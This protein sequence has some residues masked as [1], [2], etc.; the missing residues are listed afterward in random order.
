VLFNPD[1]AVAGFQPESAS[2]LF[3]HDRKAVIFSDTPIGLTEPATP[4]SQT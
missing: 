1:P 3:N 2:A 4:V